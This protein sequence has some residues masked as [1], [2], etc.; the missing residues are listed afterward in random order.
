MNGY[1]WHDQPHNMNGMALHRHTVE[2]CLQLARPCEYLRCI[3][4]LSSLEDLSLRLGCSNRYFDNAKHRIF[5]VPLLQNCNSRLGH[6]RRDSLKTLCGS[7]WLRLLRLRA[8]VPGF[9]DLVLSD[10]LES[11]RVEGNH[12]GFNLLQAM[13]FSTLPMMVL[14]ASATMWLLCSKESANVESENSFKLVNRKVA[15]VAALGEDETPSDSE[16]R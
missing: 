13:G 6:K 15:Q 10:L 14:L 4:L 9:N 8:C 2:G 11:N 3:A 16:L 12:G 7:V 1:E 5:L